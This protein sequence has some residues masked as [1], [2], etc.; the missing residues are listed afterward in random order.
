MM[1]TFLDSVGLDREFGFTSLEMTASMT[2]SDLISI[3][4]KKRRLYE[5]AI[6]DGY[7]LKEIS[8]KDDGLRHFKDA[9]FTELGESPSYE[10]PH[11]AGILAFMIAEAGRFLPVDRVL[12]TLMCVDLSIT[13]DNMS[14]NGLLKYLINGGFFDQKLLRNREFKKRC[15][16]REKEESQTGLK[17]WEME[18]RDIEWNISHRE[19]VKRWEKLETAQTI[20]KYDLDNEDEDWPEE[21]NKEGK[22]LSAEKPFNLCPFSMECSNPSII[23]GRTAAKMAKTCFAAFADVVDIEVILQ[24]TQMKYKK[25]T[26]LLEDSL[27]LPGLPSYLSK[28]ASCEDESFDSDDIQKHNLL[29]PHAHAAQNHAIL[30]SRYVLPSG[31][32]MNCLALPGLPSYLSKFASSEDEFFDSDNIQKHNLLGPHAYA[33]QNLAIMDTRYD[34]YLSGPRGSINCLV[35]PDADGGKMRVKSK[36]REINVTHDGDDNGGE[37]KRKKE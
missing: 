6:H 10:L 3:V 29:G 35:S 26:E 36:R 23:T 14:I 20:I 31:G 12:S 22:I 21:C 4:F 28:F 34:V 27:A 13:L 32:G 2:S 8:L 9:S 1:N 25:E 15:Y 19:A 33:A 30:D 37:L 24:R 5:V 17:F 16:Q 7:Q 18:Q 11:S